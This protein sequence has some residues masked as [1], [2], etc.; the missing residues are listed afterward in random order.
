MEIHKKICQK[1]L[2]SL[3]AATSTIKSILQFH[4]RRKQ[5]MRAGKTSSH[6]VPKKN[7][8][9]TTVKKREKARLKRTSLT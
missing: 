5:T 9:L 2:R 4:C 1:K 7:M 6:R 3:K 8:T